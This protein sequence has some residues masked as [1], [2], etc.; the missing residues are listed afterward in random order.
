MNAKS[1]EL[2]RLRYMAR[3]R[4][5]RAKLA[6]HEALQRRH[7]QACAELALE[8][9]RRRRA[10]NEQ[11]AARTTSWNATE[12]GGDVATHFRVEDAHRVLSYIAG[13]RLRV[14]QDAGA[15]RRAELACE[16]A[17]STADEARAEYK[18][19][20]MRHEALRSRWQRGLH[21]LQQQ[22]LEREDESLAEEQTAVCRVWNA[23]SP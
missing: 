1:R 17:R 23:R 13:A 20:V 7:T 15:I 14:R 4:D 2:E 6:S 16:R 5:V 19:A 3:V 8:E 22:E 10:E 11:Q 18:R 9:V 12:S 21:S